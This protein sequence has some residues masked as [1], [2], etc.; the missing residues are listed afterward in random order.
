MPGV[1]KFA[2]DVNANLAKIREGIAALDAQI[3][4]FNRSLAILQADLA[5]IM[6]ASASLSKAAG[7]KTPPVSA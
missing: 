5:L 2:D 4:A 6:G 7:A 3:T 1:P